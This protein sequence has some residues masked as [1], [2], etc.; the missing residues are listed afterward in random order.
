M[1]SVEKKPKP[2][3]K[4]QLGILDRVQGFLHAR[5]PGHMAGLRDVHIFPRSLRPCLEGGQRDQAATCTE[6][7]GCH[8]Y[9][10]DLDLK[11]ISVESCLK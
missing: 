3:N 5:E 1:G 2:C 7:P 6:E 8:S 11:S 4:P 9:W 10:V